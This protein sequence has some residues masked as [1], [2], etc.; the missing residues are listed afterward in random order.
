MT[1]AERNAVLSP[2][3]RTR[4]VNRLQR[5]IADAKTD[6][7]I[8]PA[9]KDTPSN[10]LVESEFYKQ[11]QIIRSAARALDIANPF[12]R[13]H[14]G[15]AGP[16]ATVDGRVCINFSSYNYLGFNGHPRVVE[17]A[18][19]AIA[20]YG[21]SCSASRLVAGERPLHR[22]L[23]QRLAALHGAEDC[24]AFVSGHATNVTV[25]GTILSKGDLI[26]YDAFSHNSVQQG[27]QLSGARRFGFAHNDV[28]AAEQVLAAQR[29]QHRR[30]LI[31]I[32]G[33][34]SMD[35]DIPDLPAFRDL[36]RR[37]GAWL[38]VDEAH[39]IGVLGKHGR[40]IG[41]H[42]GLGADAADLWMGTLSKT[43]AGCG[44]YIA[45][46]RDIAEYLRYSAPGFVYSVGMPPPMAAAAIAALELLAEEPE[47]VARLRANTAIFTEAA[48]A[49]RLDT[50]LSQ[51]YA[52]V[53]IIVGSSIAAGR[54]SAALFERGINVQPILYPAVPE[55]AARL[56]FFLSSEHTR[57]QIDRAVAI[58]AEESRKVREAKVDVA[59]LAARLRSEG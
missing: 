8:A 20:R 42:Y 7:A 45:C 24:V 22:D 18:Q 27:A 35:G 10:D 36:A 48:K 9:S 1:A 3:E 51:G 38:M 56:R 28:A 54:L 15:V 21:T 31:V 34:Y 32:E 5:G 13:V 12:F 52:I 16:E 2:T 57:T 29:G 25:I 6:A 23:E 41:E 53:P 19:A 50:G 47:R 14:E 44:G 39:S 43:L 40:G 30:A 37:H 58:T 49:A 59:A 33:H 11:M 17:A 55:R 26:L 46:R 4:L